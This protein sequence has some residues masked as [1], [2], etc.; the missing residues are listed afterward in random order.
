[1]VVTGFNVSSSVL[2]WEGCLNYGVF[3]SSVFWWDNKDLLFKLT[4]FKFWES[5]LRILFFTLFWFKLSGF[6]SLSL[7]SLKVIIV[8]AYVTLAFKVI[9]VLCNVSLLISVGTVSKGKLRWHKVLYYEVHFSFAFWHN[10]HL[11]SV[12]FTRHG[13][14]HR[15]CAQFQTHLRGFF[16]NWSQRLDKCRSWNIYQY[17]LL[18]YIQS[19]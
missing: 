5:A 10:L 14:L 13:W 8:L 3:S 19:N 16:P 12:K 18:S 9:S 15:M 17:Q 1:M 11:W 6:F 4:C 2:E 7:F